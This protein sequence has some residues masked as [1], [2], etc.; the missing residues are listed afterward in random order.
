MRYEAQNAPPAN[1]GDKD[2]GSDKQPLKFLLIRGLKSS[3]TE[4]LLAKS[5]EK[6]YLGADELPGGAAPNSLGRV[7]IVRR[8][9]TNTSTGYAFAEFHSVDA[10]IAAKQKAEQLG[11]QCTVSSQRYLVDFPHTGVFPD[12]S[13]PGKMGPTPQEFLLYMPSSERAHRYYDERYYP[14]E[15]IVNGH[16]PP[17]SMMTSTSSPAK[18]VKNPSGT[19]R[20]METLEGTVNKAKKAKKSAGPAAIPE[21]Q[22][23]Q[24]KQAELR[25]ETEQP[26][27]TATPPATDVNAI[28]VPAPQKY[29]QTFAIDANGQK[30]CYLCNTTFTSTGKLL[31]HLQ[32]S[33]THLAYAKDDSRRYRGFERLKKKDINFDTTIKLSMLMQKEAKVDAARSQ[34]D[35]AQQWRD[36][37]AERRQGEVQAG[38]Q[39]VSFSLKGKV[40]ASKSRPGSSS[41]SE[42]SK[43]AYGKG[44]GMLQKAGWKG[45]GLGADEGGISAPISQEMFAAGV[46]LG[47]EGSR[48]GDAVEEAAKLTTGERGGFQE[49]TRENARKRYESMQ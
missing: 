30:N 34:Q 39:K 49:M 27:K 10:A 4:E 3:V 24:N 47:H 21:L 40:S 1:T 18:P 6:L 19:K 9:D 17:A 42:G 28:S 26:I 22:K 20:T 12:D 14:A 36:R 33:E 2:V 23:W 5:L 37:A 46:G 29:E 48:R 25:S 32:E 31:R 43:P 7:L 44:L 13:I 11:P 38:P 15:H 16:P 8:R 41:D 35:E 45:Q